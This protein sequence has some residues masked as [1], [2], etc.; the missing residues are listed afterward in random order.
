MIEIIQ[1]YVQFFFFFNF[2][3]LQYNTSTHIIYS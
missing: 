1:L 2:I 3:L